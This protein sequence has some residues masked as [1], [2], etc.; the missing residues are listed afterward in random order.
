[1]HL[2][3]YLCLWNHLLCS[4][5]NSKRK[6]FQLTKDLSCLSFTKQCAA[7]CTALKG[8]NQRCGDSGTSA[9]RAQERRTGL[10]IYFLVK[11]RYVKAPQSV[12]SLVVATVKVIRTANK[13]LLKHVKLNA[14]KTECGG[15]VI[16][17]RP[18]EKPL[19][20]FALKFAF[21]LTIFFLREIHFSIKLKTNIESKSV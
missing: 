16:E 17:L 14:T 20:I 21:N 1:M 8:E 6:L 19:S 18:S 13:I 4:V 11:P 9:C 5:W 15:G 12:F 2:H 10:K 3:S 7:E